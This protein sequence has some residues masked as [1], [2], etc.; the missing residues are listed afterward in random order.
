MNTHVMSVCSHMLL[1]WVGGCTESDLDRK[2]GMFSAEKEQNKEQCVQDTSHLRLALL[3]VDDLGGDDLGGG[4]L[5][6]GA[7][8]FGLGDDH[9]G[10]GSGSRDDGW[11]GALNSLQTLLTLKT[12]KSCVTIMLHVQQTPRQDAET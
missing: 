12:S 9:L 1:L 4:G 5:G 10:D 2:R 11:F 7:Q 6:S 3:A 8:A